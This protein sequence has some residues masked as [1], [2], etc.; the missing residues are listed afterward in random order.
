MQTGQ[1]VRKQQCYSL[2]V[3][4]DKHQNAPAVR[5]EHFVP[6]F[7]GRKLCLRGKPIHTAHFAQQLRE[8]SHRRTC[9]SPGVTVPGR[10]TPVPFRVPSWTWKTGRRVRPEDWNRVFNT[11]SGQVTMAPTVPLHLQFEHTN[12]KIMTTGVFKIWVSHWNFDWRMCFSI[13]TVLRATDKDKWTVMVKDASLALQWENINWTQH[14]C[15]SDS[16][17]HSSC[18]WKWLC[19]WEMF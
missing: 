5:K 13:N 15:F 3:S 11:S 17:R 18:T 9:S 2:F 19:D 12:R 1:V 4:A 6:L 10:I 7:S 16:D 8:S 14:V